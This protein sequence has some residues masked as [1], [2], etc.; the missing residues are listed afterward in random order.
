[1]EASTWIS[2]EVKRDVFKTVAL[3]VA[4]E[5]LGVDVGGAKEVDSFT[6]LLLLEVELR[7]SI[8]GCLKEAS[9]AFLIFI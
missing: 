6:I 7:V 8:G 2:D 9:L 1:M 4:G 3:E 5:G